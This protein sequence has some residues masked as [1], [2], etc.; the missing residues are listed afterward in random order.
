MY[1]QTLFSPRWFLP[2]RYTKIEYNFYRNKAEVLL[3]RPDSEYH[4]CI[5]CLFSLMDNENYKHFSDDFLAAANINESNSLS[6]AKSQKKIC[7]CLTIFYT[8]WKDFHEFDLNTNKKPFMMTP[9][10]HIFH[11]P[12]L[13]KWFKEKK[14]CPSC[15][16]EIEQ[17]RI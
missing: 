10:R 11:T 17:I 8:Y 13:E 3:I 4:D 2:K 12:C 15:R 9:C 7:N 16:Q 6:L 14:E 1:S 5:I